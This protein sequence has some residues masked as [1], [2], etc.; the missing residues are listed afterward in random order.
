[1]PLSI[2]D[3]QTESP[4]RVMYNKRGVVDCPE[5]SPSFLFTRGMVDAVDTHSENPSSI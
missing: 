4:R 1:M 5:D 2:L 3:V